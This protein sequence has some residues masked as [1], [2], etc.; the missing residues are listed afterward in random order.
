MGAGASAASKAL[1]A[2][3]TADDAAAVRVS[4]AKPQEL[5]KALHLASCK[6]SLAA[7]QALLA[8]ADVDVN[9]EVKDQYG[10]KVTAIRAAI[11]GQQAAAVTMLLADARVNLGA[12]VAKPFRKITAHERSSARAAPDTYAQKWAVEKARDCYREGAP[13][14]VLAA[15]VANPQSAS[16]REDQDEAVVA[17]ILAA[18][19]AEPRVT[20]DPEIGLAALASCAS[21]ASCI[22]ALLAAK[23]RTGVDQAAVDFATAQQTIG[24]GQTWGMA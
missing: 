7:L 6:G 13:L 23:D 5:G 12:T 14:V 18:L 9:F 17:E 1:T 20:V 24:V 21:S 8:R 2:A 16:Y 22:A 15:Q 19:L 3:V 10:L 4:D 11:L